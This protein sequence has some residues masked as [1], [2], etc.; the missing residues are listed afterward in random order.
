[1]ICNKRV[2]CVK[3]AADSNVLISGSFDKTVKI[4]DMRYDNYI[5]ITFLTICIF[6]IYYLRSR[7][8]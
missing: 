6:F 7:S 3:Y 8:F 4:W 1:M 2:N 5:F